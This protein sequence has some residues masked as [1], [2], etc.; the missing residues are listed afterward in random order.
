MPSSTCT[1]IKSAPVYS[2]RDLTKRIGGAKTTAGSQLPF[3]REVSVTHGGAPLIWFEIEWEGQRAWLVAVSG[4][5]YALRDTDEEAEGDPSTG[6]D[7]WDVLLELACDEQ[8]ARA[9]YGFSSGRSGGAQVVNPEGWSWPMSVFNNCITWTGQGLQLA[10]HLLGRSGEMTQAD[11]MKVVLGD[12]P[13]DRRGAAQVAFEWG[14]GETPFNIGGAAEFTGKLKPGWYVGQGLNEGADGRL[15]TDDDTGHGF[16]IEADERGNILIL[17]SRGLAKGGSLGGQD[18][19]GSRCTTPRNAR[20][21]SPPGR[22]PTQRTPY[23]L[24]KLRGTWTDLWIS[25]LK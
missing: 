5:T 14:I 11:W 20:D 18:G 4:G 2:A 22:W 9:R 6:D 21:W 8:I 15:D 3:F 12:R 23:S 1:V 25:K 16:F 10:R 17:E 24:E 19:V 13:Y 7:P